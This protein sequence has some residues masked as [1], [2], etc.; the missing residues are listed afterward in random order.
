ME[1]DKIDEFSLKVYQTPF[2]LVTLK[3]FI[4]N[5]VQINI[6]NK[7]ND[8]QRFFFLKVLVRMV[9]EKNRNVREQPD[10]EQSNLA[11]DEWSP[12]FWSE[13]KDAILEV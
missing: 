2:P 5:L 8:Q 12:E 6:Q 4:K 3:E 13:S 10:D 11:I 1:L 9:S 7:L